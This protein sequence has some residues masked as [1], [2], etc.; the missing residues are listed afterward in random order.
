MIHLPADELGALLDVALRAAHA[1]AAELRGR[2][3]RATGVEYK[4]TSTDPVSDA[5]RASEVA[6]EA[7]IRAERPHDGLLGE[8]GMERAGTTGLR[9]VVDPLDG[10]VNYLYDSRSTP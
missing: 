7:V 10:T 9:W 6:V 2:A 5:D 4:T 1:G 3:G 8:E